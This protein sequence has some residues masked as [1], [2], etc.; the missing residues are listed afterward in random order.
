MIPYDDLVSA[1]TAW[2]ARQGLPVAQVVAAPAPAAAA[3]APAPAPAPAKPAARTAPPGA[4][5]GRAA[6]PPKSAPMKAAVVED[7]LDVDDAAFLEE[8]SSDGGDFA[9]SFDTPA[10]QTGE[11]AAPGRAPGGT[12][13]GGRDW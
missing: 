9:M 3:P 7:S 1:L 4:P 12:N 5:P 2:R 6:A 8:A 13:R 11:S 10:A